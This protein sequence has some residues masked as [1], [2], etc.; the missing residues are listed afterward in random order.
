MQA[1]LIFRDGGWTDFYFSKMENVLAGP[2]LK[3][4][5]FRGYFLVVFCMGVLG[6]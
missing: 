1:A 3:S 4:S 6:L 5:N 2:L